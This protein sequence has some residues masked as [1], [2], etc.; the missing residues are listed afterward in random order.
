MRT[1]THKSNGIKV[2]VHIPVEGEIPEYIKQQKINQL[3]D[4]LAP[5]TNENNSKKRKTNQNLS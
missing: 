4:I 5:K 1:E 3:Y 2:T